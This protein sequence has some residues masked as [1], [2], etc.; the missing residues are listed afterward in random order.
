M[1]DLAPRRIE[2]PGS[3]FHSGWVL[4]RI[5]NASIH[6]NEAG[7]RDQGDFAI[8]VQALANEFMEGTRLD[9]A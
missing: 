5:R 3:E 8:P 9:R 2:P 4:A 6:G 1:R 7:Y